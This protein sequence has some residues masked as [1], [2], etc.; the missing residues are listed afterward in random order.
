MKEQ[1]L[2][3]HI[4]SIHGLIR[5]ENLELGRDS[6]TGGQT[7]YVLEL[8]YALGRHEQVKKVNLFTR[9]IQDKTVSPDYATPFEELTD[10]VR[11]IRIQCGGAKY[12]R[13]EL[14]W[15]HLDE[16]VDKTLKFVKE[17]DEIPDVVHGH[18]ADAG[19]VALEL[20]TFWGIPC[21]F[22]GHSLGRVKRLD[23][24]ENG[25]TDKEINKRFHI[26]HRI[27]VEENVMNHADLIVASTEQE[28]QVQ[29]GHY[30]AQPSARFC[31]IPPAI[32]PDRFYPFYGD[33]SDDFEKR[34]ALQQAQFYVQR[35]LE[36]FFMHPERPLILALSRPDRRKNIPGLISAYGMDKELRAIA[37]L[38]VFAGI[39]KDISAMNANEQEILTELLLL[40]DKFDLYGKLAIPKRHDVDYEVPELY[41]LAARKQGVFVNPAFKENFGLTL[42]EAASC[43]LPIIATD[44]GGPR[45]IIKNCQNGILVDVNSPEQICEAIKDILVDQTV[46]KEYS[47]N[48]IK[49]VREH[50]TWEAHTN[51]YVT[52]LGK[53]LDRFGPKQ[54][55]TPGSGPIGRRFTHIQKFFLTD[56]DD[57]LVGDD[58]ALRQLIDVLREH[59]DVMSFGVVTGRPLNS[60]LEIL[61]DHH[62]PHPDILI[63]SVGSE[64]YYG[65]DLLPDKGWESHI[66][67]HWHRE[68]LQAALA[69]FPFLDAQEAEA[70]RRFKLSYYMEP[71]QENLAKV[72]H[73]LTQQRLRYT[74]IY[75]RDMYLD[76]LPYRAS[77]GKAIRYMHYKWNIPLRHILVSGDSKND[78]DML[79]GEMLGVVVGNHHPE[80]ERLRG[81]RHIYFAKHHYA[82]GILEGFQHYR[83]LE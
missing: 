47:Q 83:F 31:V 81:Q 27:M 15:P 53:I 56:I 19:Y 79:R 39:R 2:V 25:L 66:S 8:A 80:L 35:E 46:W 6:D 18:Y 78:E 41:R 74:L 72:H 63:S 38:A 62:I 36:R 44:D 75:S 33:P 52:R 70:Q 3:I 4:Y 17:Q 9:L 65:K 73:A 43:G 71:S 64:I 59:Q 54:R 7:K 16:F 42:I 23:L 10:K 34:E 14:L 58:E 50:Y 40:M 12:I 11:I 77:K 30:D 5:G 76:I 37:N 1:R 67:R 45:D 55:I 68:K 32:D 21:I 48:G 24:Q 26:D 82:A 13:K 20:S 69:Q 49:G 60:V 28:T 29:Y 51:T 57:T 22:T 61:E